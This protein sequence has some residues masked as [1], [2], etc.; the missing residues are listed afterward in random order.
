MAQ[1][2]Q[3]VKIYETIDIQRFEQLVTS[4]VE[5]LPEELRSKMDNIGH[6]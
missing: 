6:L 2:L 4:A 5:S 3:V 1:T